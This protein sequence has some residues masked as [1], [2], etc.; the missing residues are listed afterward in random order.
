MNQS[1]IDTLKGYWAKEYGPMT[2]TLE[3]ELGLSKT[4]A[5]LYLLLWATNTYRVEIESLKK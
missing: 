5:L 3:K 2:E 4:E 1:V